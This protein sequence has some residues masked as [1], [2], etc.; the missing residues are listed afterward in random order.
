MF[1]LRVKD[2]NDGVLG[3]K[4]IVLMVCY[5]SIFIVVIISARII[6]KSPT[7]LE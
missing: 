5:F 4:A 7:L 6:T 2:Q 3:P 1:T